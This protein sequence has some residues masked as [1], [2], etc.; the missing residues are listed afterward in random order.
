VNAL[1]DR[2]DEERTA[3]EVAQPENL[4]LRRRLTAHEP[5]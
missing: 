4:E 5:E 2:L 1:P 3:L